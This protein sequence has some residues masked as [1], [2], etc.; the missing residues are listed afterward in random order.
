MN[1]LFEMIEAL[2]R[3][4]YD[5]QGEKIISVMYDIAETADGAYDE[6]HVV[7]NDFAN[8]LIDGLYDIAEDYDEGTPEEAAEYTRRVKEL[9]E[10]AKTLIN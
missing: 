7:G 9:Y 6:L 5:M 1:R 10:H 4:E 2:L 3:G 8:L